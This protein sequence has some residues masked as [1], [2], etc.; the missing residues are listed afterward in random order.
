M[1]PSLEFLFELNGTLEPALL[2]GET[3]HGLRRVVPIAGGTF[4]GPGI[5]GQVLRGGADWQ[6]V[7]SDGVAELE[8]LYLLL[9]D[10]G[11]RIQVHNR[12][13]RHGPDAVMKRL[14]A[15]EPVEPGEY[16]FRAAPQFSAP[17]GHYEW[18][19]R[20]LFLCTGTRSPLGIRVWFY[21]VA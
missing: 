19:N 2:V 1:K 21:R 15:G 9:T 16:Y 17:A 7:R 11:V 4:E 3:P 6:V 18:L 8:A 13:I 20:S 10:D 5:R 12:G 14:A